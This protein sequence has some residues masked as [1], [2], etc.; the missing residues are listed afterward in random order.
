VTRPREITMLDPVGEPVAVSRL[1]ELL[2]ELL[3]EPP[4][5]LAQ[6]SAPSTDDYPTEPRRAVP[7]VE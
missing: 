4:V 2:L 1:A 7:A 6:T 5:Q 3:A